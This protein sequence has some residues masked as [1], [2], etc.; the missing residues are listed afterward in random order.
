M[1]DNGK[2]K[3]KRALELERE[4]S[5]LNKELQKAKAEYEEIMKNDYIYDKVMGLRMGG[6][7]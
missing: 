5:R 2:A 7:L 6:I 4:M 3:V 1:T